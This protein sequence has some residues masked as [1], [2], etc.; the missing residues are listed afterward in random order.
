MDRNNLGVDIDQAWIM[1]GEGDLV[2]SRY[3]DNVTQAVFNS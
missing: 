2:L 3:E 1:E